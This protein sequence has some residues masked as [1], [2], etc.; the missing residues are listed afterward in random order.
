LPFL[1]RNGPV[2]R[3]QG[4]LDFLCTALHDG[5]KALTGPHFDLVTHHITQAAHC[6]AILIQDWRCDANPPTIDLTACNRVA[7]LSDTGERV[8]EFLERIT[9]M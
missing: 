9:E 3:V 2:E 7:G 4:G 1:C 6:P 5:G 8:P